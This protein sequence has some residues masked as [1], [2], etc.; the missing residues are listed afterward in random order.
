MSG[1]RITIDGLLRCLCPSIDA[2]VT[3]RITTARSRPQA[4]EPSSVALQ[5]VPGPRCVHTKGRRREKGAKPEPDPFAS[6]ANA[7]NEK[8]VFKRQ[9]APDWLKQEGPKEQSLEDATSSPE[10]AVVEKKGFKH[11]VSPDWLEQKEPKEQPLESAASSA[12]DGDRSHT[13]DSIRAPDESTTKSEPVAHLETPKLSRNASESQDGPTD[14]VQRLI[15]GKRL[16]EDIPRA[17]SEQIYEALRKLRT[18]GNPKYRR[19]TSALVRHLL[20]T[21]TAPDTFLYETLL[22]AHAAT[23]GSADVVKELL[24]EMR[25]KKL[26]WSSTAYH[27]A[28]Q[29]RTPSP[30]AVRLPC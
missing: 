23:D 3:R 30:D 19:T 9:L 10:D 11:Q 4:R 22:M 7:V 18:L 17:N 28:L 13:D 2:T 5:A 29:V 25:Q 6:L 12:A 20:A 24:R 26:P 8:K 1:A 21:G 14:M 15:W 16:D 27:A